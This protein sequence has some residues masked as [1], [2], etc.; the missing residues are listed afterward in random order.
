MNK[1]LSKLF[2]DTLSVLNIIVLTNCPCARTQNHPKT[3]CIKCLDRRLDTTNTST[4]SLQNLR[5][6]EEDSTLMQTV[7]I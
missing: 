4:P 7:Y 6:T 2:A 3:S 5:T 1:K